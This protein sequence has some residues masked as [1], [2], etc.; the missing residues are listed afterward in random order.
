MGFNAKHQDGTTYWH[1]ST[2][3]DGLDSRCGGS[4]ILHC[5]CG[6]DL[7]VCGNFGE[8]ECDGCPDCEHDG[9]DDDF[10]D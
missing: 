8:V 10:D 2:P 6:G 9:P 5:H 4:G 1:A 7:C 3:A